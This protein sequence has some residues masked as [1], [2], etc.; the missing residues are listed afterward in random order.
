MNIAILR[1]FVLCCLLITAALC[2]AAGAAAATGESIAA[3]QSPSQALD[4]VQKAL[5]TGDVALFERHVD[6]DAL[7]AAAVD[8]F[9][10]DA[11]SPEGKARLSPVVAMILSSVSSSADAQQGLRA[12]IGR[13][14]RNFIVY[15]VQ[16]GNFAGQ[17]RAD[18]PAPDGLLAP[19][20]AEASLGRKEIQRKGAPVADG[21]DA[22]ISFSVYDYGNGR[23]Y[24][25]RGR[26]R[27][28]NAQWRLVQ[29][30]NLPALV[31]Q[32]RRESVE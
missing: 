20:F 31:D 7:V 14:A 6:V 5:N 28:A 18:V 24:P 26:M 32:L 19:L 13:E 9:L 4:A 22:L 11:Q 25:V 21:K 30:E 10:A 3:P 8:F 27:M 1:T 2:P 15:G 29:V 23:S 17:S 12:L 16:S